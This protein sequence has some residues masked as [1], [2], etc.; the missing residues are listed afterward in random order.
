VIVQHESEG[1]HQR[2]RAFARGAAEPADDFERLALDLA[3]FQFRWIPG[4]RRLVEERRG[5]I[6]RLDGI[7][8]VPCDAFRLTRIAVHSSELDVVRFYTSGTTGNPGVH[9]MR[10]TETY[11]ELSLKWATTAL[12]SAWEGRPLVVA[13]APHPGRPATSSLGFMMRT[14]MEVFDGRALT[15]DPEG[16]SFDPDAPERWLA[17]SSGIDVAGL[18]R[19]ALVARERQEPLVVLSTSF[20]LVLLLEALAGAGLPTPKSTVVMQTGGFKGRTR[21]VTP[22]RLRAAIARA[23]R[24]AE[25]N[26]IG[27]YGMTELSS[28]LYEGGCAAKQLSGERGVYYE[29]PWLRVVPVDPATLEPVRDGD[30]GIARIVDLANVDSAAVIVTQDLVRRR[31]GGIELLGRRRS[32]APRGCSLAVEVLVSAQAGWGRAARGS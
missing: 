15:R 4:Y 24:I 10:T 30:V 22:E 5:S 31:A 14:F 17:S 8:A 18:R 23:L 12:A 21:Q 26:I 1:L 25:H 13:L 32:A 9:C 16:A 6:D 2:V 7:P 20:A 3:R 11:R 29:P 28:Q 27:E 19:A